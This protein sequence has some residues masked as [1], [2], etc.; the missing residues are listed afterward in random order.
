MDN[1]NNFIPN[2]E[3]VDSKKSQLIKNCILKSE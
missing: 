1:N 3:V 2:E